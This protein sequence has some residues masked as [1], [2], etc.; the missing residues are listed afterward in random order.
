M[1]DLGRDIWFNHSEDRDSVL[2]HGTAVALN[3]RSLVLLGPSG[4]G[5]SSTAL[6]M[7]ACGARLISDDRVWIKRGAQNKLIASAPDRIAG[8][9]EARGIG[10]LKTD[11]QEACHLCYAV[12]LSRPSDARCPDVEMTYVCGLAL[13]LV[14]PR[15]GP[16]VPAAL[17]CLLKYG[18]VDEHR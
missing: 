1:G 5:K 12:D 11:I 7:I 17:I 18:F 6:Q 3:D 2:C 8:Q 16:E 15:K 13:R 14:R 10:I 9:I 4:V